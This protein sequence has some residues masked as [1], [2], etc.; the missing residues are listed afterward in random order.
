MMSLLY[1][2]ATYYA[3]YLVYFSH[4]VKTFVLL[5]LDFLC[6]YSLET[7]NVYTVTIK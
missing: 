3:A 1:G 2:F 5:R 4:S 7:I 6:F